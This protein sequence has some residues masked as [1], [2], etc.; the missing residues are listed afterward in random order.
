MNLTDIT[1]GWHGFRSGVGVYYYHW[2]QPQSELRELSLTADMIGLSNM[3][4]IEGRAG[5]P[6]PEPE[7]CIVWQ[8]M[9]TLIAQLKM[10][11]TILIEKSW[12]WPFSKC[13]T[14]PNE[15]FCEHKMTEMEIIRNCS[16]SYGQGI[17]NMISVN[18]YSAYHIVH[19]IWYSVNHISNKIWTISYGQD[20]SVIDPFWR[21]LYPAID[22]T[23]VR[24]CNF[25]VTACHR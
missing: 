12:S 1:F 23:N 2:T 7:V 8:P 10:K 13:S 18:Q 5:S 4:G 6:D 24:E 9:M 15:N 22:K 14:K 20:F 19:I 16:C 25:T 11:K 3:P 21:L 17:H